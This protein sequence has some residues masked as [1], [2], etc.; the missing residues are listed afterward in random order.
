M[1]DS[2]KSEKI[3]KRANAYCRQLNI[4]FDKQGVN[5]DTINDM[6]EHDIWDA[7]K[8][9]DYM[10]LAVVSLGYVEFLEQRGE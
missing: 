9:G 4:M 7:R 5:A 8:Q 6:A 2:I 1:V 10:L 3:A